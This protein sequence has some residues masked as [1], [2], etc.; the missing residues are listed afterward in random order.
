MTETSPAPSGAKVTAAASLGVA[1]YLEGPRRSAYSLGTSSHTAWFD[2][3]G[4]VIVLGDST[5]VRQANSVVIAGGVAGAVL[6][7]AG[8]SV[9]V[10]EGEVAVGPHRVG[11]ARWWDPHPTLSVTSPDVIPLFLSA[12]AAIVPPVD[13]EP[14]QAALESGDPTRIVATATP[15]I[16]RGTGLTPTGDDLVTGAFGAYRLIGEARGVSNNGAVLDRVAA[17]LDE[18]LTVTTSFSASVVRHALAGRVAAPVA[19]TLRA[20]IGR[21]PLDD[22]FEA[23]LRVG[24][25]SGRAL[26]QGVLIGAGAAC[27]GSS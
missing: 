6:T 4:D 3:G 24:H 13:A 19:Q 27:G 10:G 1:E 5:V 17:G 11:I 18:T 9:H 22:A 8:E 15:Y 25:T 12:A 2:V 26:A 20:L 23:L 7:A 16:G 14:L 21:A